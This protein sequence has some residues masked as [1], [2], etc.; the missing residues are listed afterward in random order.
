MRRLPSTGPFHCRFDRRL[1]GAAKFFANRKTLGALLAKTVPLVPSAQVV[2]IVDRSLVYCGQ[3]GTGVAGPT[4]LS[5][6]T[7]FGRP[8]LSSAWPR[9]VVAGVFWKRPTPPRTTAR[10]MRAAPSKLAICGAVPYVHEKPARGLTYALFGT[11]SFRTPKML[12]IC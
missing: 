1:R 9:S 5:C 7:A 3:F 4:Q 10:G 12:S 6:C 8:V 11:R 2:G